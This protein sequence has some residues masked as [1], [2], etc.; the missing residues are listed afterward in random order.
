[1]S[2]KKEV[3]MMYEIIKEDIL[4]KIDRFGNVT[5]ADIENIICRVHRFPKMFQHIIMDELIQ[6][7][8]LIVKEGE[9]HHKH[10]RIFK[11]NCIR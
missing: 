5:E 3:I 2:Q 6:L 9:W 10:K 11:V 4:K 1:M 8:Y 7:E